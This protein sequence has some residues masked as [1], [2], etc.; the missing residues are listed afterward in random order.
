MY[1]PLS[2]KYQSLYPRTSEQG[3]LDE[4]EGHEFGGR[5]EIKRERDRP[6][7]WHIVE[8]AMAEGRLEALRD[9]QGPSMI[10]ASSKPTKANGAKPSTTGEKNVQGRGGGV[11]LTGGACSEEDE[12]DDMSDGGFFEK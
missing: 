12:D 2:E 9:G 6:P 5:G 3:P 10:V 11:K 4:S 7:L 8:L 1:F